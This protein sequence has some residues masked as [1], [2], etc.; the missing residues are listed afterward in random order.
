M[1]Q[2]AQVDALEHLLL[3]VLKRNKMTLAVETVFEEAKGLILGSD[4]PGGPAEKTKA[5]EYLKHLELQIR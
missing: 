1:T 4:G 5:I 2:Q 3:A